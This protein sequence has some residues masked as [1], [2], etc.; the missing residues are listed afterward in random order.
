[1]KLFNVVLVLLDY[2]HLMF[3]S[4]IKITFAKSEVKLR[5]SGRSEI[6][7]EVSTEC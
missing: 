5:L 4:K 1:M 6:E 2:I 3:E 7:F